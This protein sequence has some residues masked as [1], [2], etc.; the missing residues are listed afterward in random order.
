MAGRPS[1]KPKEDIV[2]STEKVAVAVDNKEDIMAILKQMQE[3]MSNLKKENEDLKKVK[4]PQSKDDDA[5][6]QDTEIEVMSLFSGTMTLYTEGFGNGTPYKFEDG[7]GS[8]IDIPLGDLKLIVKN[9]NKLAKSGAFYIL[10]EE[11]VGA[12]R[13]KKIYEGLIDSDSMENISKLSD[14][15]IMS[16]YKSAHKEQQELILSYFASK[17]A[18]NQPI[19]RNLIFALEEECGKKLTVSE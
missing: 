4:Q 12:V 19:S 17:L 9:N 1:T 5:L 8:I 13:L 16:L 11:V 3:E 15:N 6:T 10:N 7:Y 2:T 14:D 18:E